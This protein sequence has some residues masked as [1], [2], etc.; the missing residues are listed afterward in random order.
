M[1]KHKFDHTQLR[2]IS[3]SVNVSRNLL[4]NY[5]CKFKDKICR[6]YDLQE[7]HWIVKN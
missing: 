1:R 7:A 2:E 5:I 4:T 6:K 3:I